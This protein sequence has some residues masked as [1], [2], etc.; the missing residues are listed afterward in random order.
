MWVGRKGRVTHA[1][2]S[3]AGSRRLFEAARGVLAG[4]GWYSMVRELALTT[5][6]VERGGGVTLTLY[7]AAARA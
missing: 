2:V 4:S 6:C 1:D 5:P 3:D 7:T